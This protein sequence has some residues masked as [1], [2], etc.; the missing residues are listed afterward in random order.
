MCW[1]L[2]K[3]LGASPMGSKTLSTAARKVQ[4]ISCLS[5]QKPSGSWEGS[6]A[7]S[8]STDITV[9]AQRVILRYLLTWEREQAALGCLWGASN[10]TASCGCDAPTVPRG[11]C[12]RCNI[13]KGSS[14]VCTQTSLQL[15]LKG[16]RENMGCPAKLAAALAVFVPILSVLCP[17]WTNKQHTM[18]VP[19]PQ[20]AGQAWGC[21]TVA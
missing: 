7:G 3:P 14:W 1:V 17:A 20:A 16:W 18:C 12:T 9:N 15:T 8:R 21:A 4:S 2:C 19:V 11:P 13:R 5:S 10:P 6:G